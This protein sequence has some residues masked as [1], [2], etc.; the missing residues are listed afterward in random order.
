[1]EIF[2]MFDGLCPEDLPLDDSPI[3][4]K[5]VMGLVRAEVKKERRRPERLGRA[6][7]TGLIAAALAAFLGVTA[8]AAYELFIDKYV[9]DQPAYYETEAQAQ[10]RTTARI[11]LTGYQGTPEYAAYTEWEAYMNDWW[12]KAREHDPWKERGVD[13]SWHETPDN[14]AGLYGA[15]FQDQADAL[16]AIVEKYGLTLHQDEAPY[17]QST[18]LYE[19]LGTEPFF[20]ESVAKLSEDRDVSGYV[21]DDGSFKAEFDVDLSGERTV[22]MQMFVNAKGSFATI[23]GVAEMTE[24]CEAW[25]YTT[26]SGRSVD[27]YLAPNSAELM[28]EI[29]GAY[30]S[31]SAHAGSAPSYDP[32]ADPRLSEEEKRSYLEDCL[33]ND[34]D[35]T[36]AEQEAAWQELYDWEVEVQRSMLPTAI[37]KE[38][39]QT[40]ADSIDFAVLA[41]RFDGTAHPE[42]AD[43]LPVLKARE[44]ERFTRPS[45]DEISEQEA[46]SREVIA[47][48]DIFQLTPPAGYEDAFL[49]GHRLDG[50]ALEWTDQP[51]G[52]VVTR[53][54]MGGNGAGLIELSWYRFYADEER[55]NS[56]TAEALAEAREFY[57]K[58]GYS[59]SEL[60]VNGCEGSVF[61][62]EAQEVRAAWYDP[63]RDLLFILAAY[64]VDLD[65]DSVAE[66]AATVT[67]QPQPLSTPIPI[68]Q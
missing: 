7:R 61:S 65:A 31:V 21:Y 32:A 17:Y 23:S 41:D 58:Q 26:K 9:I 63:E 1:M 33:R 4:P 56:T 37:T 60:E 57:E 2:D 66:L 3:D 43:M 22:S 6:V 16:D 35:M 47:Q 20:G 34:P 50:H 25:Q 8:Y 62:D 55:T 11:S 36:E 64:D 45:A 68:P 30:I 10:D 48:W 59:V 51:S 24:D 12:E 39:L 5:R 29:E 52:D 53:Q 38:D 67:A 27:L 15:S 28:A 13:D 14:Y 46:A 42:T 19:A 49:S 44:A 54:Y 40:I 18:D